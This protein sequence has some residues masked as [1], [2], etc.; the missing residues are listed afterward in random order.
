MNLH[1]SCLRGFA[2]TRLA[3]A[4]AD[5]GGLGGPVGRRVALPGDREVGVDAQCAG[6]ERGGNLGGE[7]ESAVLRA[8]LGPILRLFSR[9]VSRAPLIGRPGCPPGKSQGEGVRAPM[10][11]WPSRLA[12]TVRASAAT[13]SGR[14][15]GTCPSWRHTS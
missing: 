5:V 7:L 2:A 10:V 12:T 11:G 4:T 14:W 9:R 1:G 6:E 8:W 15:M 13:G 3:V